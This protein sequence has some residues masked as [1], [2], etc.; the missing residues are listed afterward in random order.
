M[1][2]TLIAW[3]L[4]MLSMI[5]D[6]M[7]PLLQTFLFRQNTICRRPKEVCA[8]VSFGQREFRRA[9][10][11]CILLL[12]FPRFMCRAAATAIVVASYACQESAMN[13]S[14]SGQGSHEILS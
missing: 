9:T 7:I 13:F 4:E 6:M 3:H 5:E 10:N 12:Y 1:V 2:S 11:H 14:L 8:K